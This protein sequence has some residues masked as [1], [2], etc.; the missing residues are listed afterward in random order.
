[1]TEKL[2]AFV[3]MPFDKEF[4]DV[5]ALG[6]K[7]AVEELGMLA[8][9]VDEQIF[10]GQGILER[11]YGQ[12]EA[13]DFIIADM[14]GQNPN[15]FYEVGY[16]HAQN[17]LCI[18]LT[19][20][21]SDIPFDLKHQRHIVYASIQEL[22]K[23]LLNDLAMMKKELAARVIPIEVLKVQ[24]VYLE[25]RDDNPTT[26]YKRKL[27]I[28]VR[29]EGEYEVTVLAARWRSHTG[30]IATQPLDRHVWQIAGGKGWESNSWR[31]AEDPMVRALPGQVLRTWIGLDPSADE[32]EVRRRHVT[33]RLGTLIVPLQINGHMFD[34]ILR[35]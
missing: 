12:I 30:D 18:L 8:E 9:R 13:T 6:I 21:A 20:N 5:Y 19:R 17:K 24:D 1:M 23:S 25:R 26:K 11:I 2:F 34:Q 28:V 29:N 22:K 33:R 27:R 31:R 7:S 4:D 15:V 35:L 10:H 16:A 3:L 32:V 14:S